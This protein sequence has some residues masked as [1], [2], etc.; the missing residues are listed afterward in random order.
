MP[1][2]QEFPRIHNPQRKIKEGPTPLLVQVSWFPGNCC[3]TPKIYWKT[4]GFLKLRKTHNLERGFMFQHIPCCLQRACTRLI[5]GKRAGRD[6]KSSPSYSS[7]FYPC[8][9]FTDFQHFLIFQCLLPLWERHLAE[10]WLGDV[11]LAYTKDW[12]DFAKL[13]LFG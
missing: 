2:G 8:A 10:W 5:T 4:T 3:P 11:E 13:F 6:S 1:F 12:T 9:W 7:Q